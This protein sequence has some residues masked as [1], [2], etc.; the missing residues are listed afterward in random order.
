MNINSYATQERLHLLNNPLN[1]LIIDNYYVINKDAESYLVNNSSN[2]SIKK[3][4]NIGPIRSENYFVNLKDKKLNDIKFKIKNNKFD[5]ISLVFDWQSELNYL[6]NVELRGNNWLNNKNFYKVICNI[7]DKNKDIIFMIKGKNYNFLKIKYFNEINK[8]LL[9]KTNIVFANNIGQLNAYQLM[10]I[11]D[12]SI[13]RYSS[14][15]EEM[16]FIKF[17]FII[18]D[19]INFLNEEIKIDD[20]YIANNIEQI[21][22]FITNTKENLKLDNK[23]NYLNFKKAKTKFQLMLE[24]E[25]NNF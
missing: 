1:K 6:N 19:D 8:E 7:A 11:S 14:V 17:P 18:F 21:E 3:V 5:F 10:S 12:F 13:S 20:K 16:K 23:N 9:N 22:K 25:I 4:I 2:H 24:N 15:C